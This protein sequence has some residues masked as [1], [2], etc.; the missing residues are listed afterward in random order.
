MTTNT[1]T[2][3]LDPEFREAL[4]LRARAAKRSVSE[5]VNDVIRLALAEDAE[6][7]AA[8]EERAGEPDLDFDEVVEDLKRRGKL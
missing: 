8:F 7:L 3:E 2:I 5:I 6:D 4:L 1:A